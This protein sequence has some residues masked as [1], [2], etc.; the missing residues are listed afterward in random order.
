MEE[1]IICNRLHV[2]PLGLYEKMMKY[3]SFKSPQTL[4]AQTTSIL[5]QSRKDFAKKSRLKVFI[6]VI[7]YNHIMPTRFTLDV[8]L[9]NI[10]TFDKLETYDKKVVAQNVSLHYLFK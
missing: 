3:M 6:K 8:D 10:V 2:R 4:K 7:N 9:K 5:S 1:M